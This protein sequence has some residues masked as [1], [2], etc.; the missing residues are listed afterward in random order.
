MFDETTRPTPSAMA[1]ARSTEDV[2]AGGGVGGGGGGSEGAIAC[3]D[4]SGVRFLSR[5]GGS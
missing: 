2:S 1:A 5:S 3:D 4:V